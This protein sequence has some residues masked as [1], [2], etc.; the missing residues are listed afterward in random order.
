MEKSLR[1]AKPI[2][3]SPRW[4]YLIRPRWHKMFS[5]LTSNLARSFL[6]IASIAVGLFAVGMIATLN[7]T[8]NEDI[9]TSYRS[10]N[11][12]NITVS[13]AEMDKKEIDSVRRIEGVHEA[14]GVRVFSLRLK[15]GPNEWTRINIKALPEFEKSTINRLLPVAG[16]FI[17]KDK[18]IVF[19]LHKLADAHIQIG[20]MVEVMLP[21]G[22]IKRLHFVGT[23]RDQSIGA[24]GGGGYFT[25]PLTGYIHFDTLSYLSQPQRVNQILATVDPSKAE[26]LPYI[27][28]VTDRV[29]E[30]LEKNNHPVLNQFSRLQSQHPNKIYIEAMRSILF[31]LGFFVTILSTFLIT[32]TL[33]ALLNQQKEQIGIMKTYGGKSIQIIGIYSVLILIYSVLGLVI[34]LSF[35]GS[36]AYGL[37]HFLSYQ[38]NFVPSGY[39]EVPLAIVLQIVLA[40]IVPLAAGFFPILKAARIPIIQ[41]FEVTSTEVTPAKQTAWDETWM[42]KTHLPRPILLSIRNTFR[43]K[44]RLALTLATLTLGGAIF[45][46]TFSV[47]SSMKTY[48]HSVSKYFVA[49]LNLI[50]DKS[51]RIEDIQNTLKSL[52]Q[53]ANVEGWASARAELLK[54]G[55]K[56]G[57]SVSLLAPPADS[58]LITPNIIQGRWIVEGD[59]NAIVLNETF[60]NRFPNMKVGDT[61]RLRVNGDKT[62]W[63]IVGFF[64]FA[65]KPAGFLAYANYDYLSKIIHQPDKASNFHIVSQEALT[66][67]EEQKAWLINQFN[68]VVNP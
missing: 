2:N 7:T 44:G 5:D 34:S 22:T 4:G 45:I 32:N 24:L 46:A 28:S 66:T 3:L 68:R 27:Q 33:S 52:P 42:R 67:I 37:L 48:I 8:L 25:A 30:K 12:A 62:T 1:I 50:F 15:S 23:V 31:G 39:R 40:A 11:P 6:V 13:I 10:I 9:V 54:E 43:Q 63:I 29:V 16:K 21:D 14:E 20:Q 18:Q 59:Q 61:L 35:S 53:V 38:V 36:A 41:A 57:E 17:P 65:G 64:Q 55:D 49:D 51:Y 47:Q 19:D 56:P 26:D 58:T 60:L